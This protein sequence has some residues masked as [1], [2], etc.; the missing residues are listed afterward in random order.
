MYGGGPKMPKETS[1]SLV[2]DVIGVL[3]NKN[4]EEGTR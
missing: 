1:T 2:E 4:S 3:K